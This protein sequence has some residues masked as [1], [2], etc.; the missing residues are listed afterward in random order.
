MSDATCVAML[1]GPA[2]FVAAQLSPEMLP[3]TGMY[4]GA[5]FGTLYG[6]LTSSYI[7]SVSTD[8]S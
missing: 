4:G 2:E 8:L 5:L 7:L 6:A 1:K 3:F